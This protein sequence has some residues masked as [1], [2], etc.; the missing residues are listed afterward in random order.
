MYEVFK[1]VLELKF[2]DAEVAVIHAEK[3]TDLSALA[4]MNE[5]DLH[6]SV[7]RASTVL[8]DNGKATFADAFKPQLDKVMDLLKQHPALSVVIEAHTD[9]NGS[10]DFNFKLSQQRAQSILDYFV[11]GGTSGD[12]LVPVGHGENHPIADNK[13]LDGRAQNRRVEF[14]LVMREDQAYE[15]P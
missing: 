6:N 1:K 3:V 13:T 12:R 10:N 14:R 7:V 8:F 4:L 15:K 9:A 2:M 5:Q 11:E